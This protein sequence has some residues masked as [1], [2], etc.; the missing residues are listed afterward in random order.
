MYFSVY[1]GKCEANKEKL[2]YL[3]RL[4]FLFVETFFKFY[5]INGETGQVFYLS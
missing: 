3:K 5:C 2:N 1:V 4:K